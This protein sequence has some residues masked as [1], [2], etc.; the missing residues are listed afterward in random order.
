MNGIVSRFTTFDKLLATGLIKVLYWVGIV[1]IAIGVLFGAFSAFGQ[2]FLAGLGTII[3]A[4]I[5]GAVALIFWR[6]LC[7]IYIA[8]FGMYNRLGDISEKLDRRPSA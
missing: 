1:F 5:V 8:I 4:P 3:A 2:G 7:E 6:F